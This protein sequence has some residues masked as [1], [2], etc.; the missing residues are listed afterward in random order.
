MSVE[1]R[2]RVEGEDEWE[3]SPPKRWRRFPRR[4]LSFLALFLAVAAGIVGVYF[5]HRVQEGHARLKRELETAANLEAQA[6]RDADRATFLSLHDGDDTRWYARQEDRFAQEIGSAAES[7]SGQEADLA[8]LEAA[9]LPEGNRAW[10][11]VSWA[12]DDGV[13]RRVQF[14]R[15][16]EGQ[17]LRTGVRREYY[18]KERTHETAHFAFTYLTRDEPTVMWMAEQLET[19]YEA[20]C[21]DFGCDDEERINVL[22]TGLEASDTGYRPPYGFTLSSPRLRGVGEDGALLPEEQRELARM[23]VYLLAAQQTGGRETRQQPY[24]LSLSQVY[25]S[26]VISASEKVFVVDSGV[27]R[28]VKAGATVYVVTGEFLDVEGSEGTFLTHV[29]SIGDMN[30][31]QPYL[32]P[33]FVNWEMRRL[34]LADDDTPPTPVLDS[35]MATYG[36]ERVRALRKAMG[37]TTFEDEAV[38]L[39]VGVGLQDLNMVFGRYLAALLAVERQMIEWQVSDLTGLTTAPLA[40][41]TFDALLD[42]KAGSWRSL[43]DVAFEEWSRHRGV[44]FYGMP[45]SQPA[46]AQWE[47][48][49][50]STIWAEVSY[51]EAALADQG[52]ILRRTEFFRQVNGAWRHAPPDERFLGKEVVVNSAHFCI[53]CHEREAPLVAEQLAQLEASYEAISRDLGTSLPEGECLAI[54]L[55]MGAGFSYS[56]DPSAF[57]LP[58][59]FFDSFNDWSDVASL[60]RRY[61]FLALAMQK[62]DALR[63]SAGRPDLWL[64]AIAGWYAASAR[65]RFDDHAWSEEL[66][67]AAQAGDF[68][69]LAD[70]W[71]DWVWSINE[72]DRATL[73]VSESQAAVCYI[74]ETYGPD[75]L[76]ALVEALGE[77]DS[78]A[79]WL[80]I[81]LGVDLETFEADW[82]AW[83]RERLA[84]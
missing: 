19:W 57:Q 73:M 10:A 9:W 6:R 48:L 45:F 35:V 83:L 34:G 11:E 68:V 78:T 27:L 43:K 65:C 77:A 25:P 58:S 79:S 72:A 37:Q 3:P 80:R 69:P 2:W 52:E 14:Y 5:W 22:I 8:V 62:V 60:S 76:P 20:V 54:Q 21:A 13:Y 67:S 53:E 40:R 64:Q 41:Q 12:L 4:L 39:A 47:T 55:M 50:D 51:Q 33:Q 16:V 1:F 71:R 32:L 75:T 49:D 42:A 38:R 36:V 28:T 26:K 61:I 46:V 15:Q 29:S 63:L 59:P 7:E 18:G 44:L 84:R 17:W 24:W 82:Q 31:I 56:A 74:M 23:L 81:A 30:A 70:V 66:R